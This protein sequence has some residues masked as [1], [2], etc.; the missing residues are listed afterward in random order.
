VLATGN[1]TFALLSKN[2]VDH[3]WKVSI[4]RL[5]ATLAFVPKKAARK[6]ARGASPAVVSGL[7]DRQSEAV[8]H[9]KGALLILAGAGSGKTK[10]LTHR[11]AHL[12]KNEGVPAGHILAV[13]FTNKAAGEM[14]ERLKTILAG[15]GFAGELPFVGTFHAFGVRVLHREGVRLGYGQRFAIYDSDD[16]VATIK[17]VLAELH[18]DPK[19]FNPNLLLGLISR[20]KNELLGPEEMA[21]R[22]DEF[23]EE[24]AAK[25]Y[26]RYQARL[27]DSN[28]VDFDDLLVLPVRIFR[29]FPQVLERYQDRFR[30]LHVDEYQDTNHAQYTLIKLLAGKRG[31]VA[32]VGDDWQAIY[33]WRGASLRNILEFERDFPDAHI[34]LLEQNYRSTQT[35]LDA[36]GAVIAKNEDQKDKELWTENGT[37]DKVVIHQ[38]RDERDEAEYVIKRIQQLQRDGLPLS[39]S[40]VLYRTNA[41]SRPIEEAC[42]QA[43][44]PYRMVGGMKF[45]DRKE[46][47]D[48]MAYLK[49]VANPKDIIAYERLLNTPTRGLGP[50]TRDRIAQHSQD[51]HGGDLLAAMLDA[52]AIEDVDAVRAAAVREVGLTL[53]KLRERHGNVADLIDT[54]VRE[55]GFEKFLRDGSDEGES[56]FENVKELRTV[57]HG[58]D[59]LD[60]FLEQVALVSDLDSMDDGRPALTL[61]TT[62]AAKGLEFRHVYVVGMEEGVFP[63]S[64][65]L[66]EPRELAEERRLCYVAMTRARE[67]LTMVY[68]AQRELYG[69]VQYNTPSRFLDDV[70]SSLVQKTRGM[71]VD[72]VSIGSTDEQPFHDDVTENAFSKGERVRHPRFGTGKIVGTEDDMVEVVFDQGGTRTLSVSFAP[73][74]RLS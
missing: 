2:N 26:A 6:A 34:V 45:Y 24:V 52:P 40:V 43:D 46:V 69:E 36:A 74:E 53:H 48:V 31:N 60:D 70:P 7:N 13:T 66:V 30:Y 73:L 61:M 56:R 1:F 63:H 21:K 23:L 47:K 37:G 29:E 18:L 58:R 68:T 55:F 4:F 10:A 50:K 32:V 19:Q 8:L 33:G 11:I 35:I 49:F 27:A 20:A 42:L 64:R 16:Q 15:Q 65:S 28:A 44:M 57:A 12:I 9:T 41:Q 25:V 67:R 3:S 14:R 17:A 54:V 59:S 62:H 5:S 51:Q 71:G 72:A 39:E 38:A 22:A